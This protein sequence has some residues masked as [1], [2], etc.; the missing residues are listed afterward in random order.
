MHFSSQLRTLHDIGLSRVQ[1]DTL[2]GSSGDSN[3]E[4]VRSISLVDCGFVPSQRTD[5]SRLDLERVGAVLLIYRDPKD[6]CSNAPKGLEATV[7]A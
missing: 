4:Y 2:R 6:Q 3:I 7:K 5:L 1:F